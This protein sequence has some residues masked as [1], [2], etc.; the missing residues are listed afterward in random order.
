M[1]NPALSQKH[2]IAIGACLAL[3][4]GGALYRYFTAPPQATSNLQD[5]PLHNTTITG[6]SIQI[7]PLTPAHQ[8]ANIIYLPATF[9]DSIQSD[10]N[11]LRYEL[12]RLGFV[13]S[14]DTNDLNKRIFILQEKAENYLTQ[15]GVNVKMGKHQDELNSGQTAL[16]LTITIRGSG[17]IIEDQPTWGNLIYSIDFTRQ[18]FTSRS[19]TTPVTAKVLLNDSTLESLGL[20]SPELLEAK[21]DEAL[22]KALERVVALWKAQNPSQGAGK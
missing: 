3:L 1:K 6:I 16:F 17:I 22:G 19:A 18:F 10:L 11:S 9:P 4:C 13:N 5:Q 8:S 21:Q 14:D 12:N 7:A 20:V 2:I 15:A